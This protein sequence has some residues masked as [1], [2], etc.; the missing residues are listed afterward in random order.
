MCVNQAQCAAG[1]QKAECTTPLPG[2]GA[3][4]VRESGILHVTGGLE[5]DRSPEEPIRC[6]VKGLRSCKKFGFHCSSS[7]ESL[8]EFKLRLM[9][10]DASLGEMTGS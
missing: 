3:W 2:K 4:G 9:V 7:E 6:T 8:E 5:K 1:A 10:W